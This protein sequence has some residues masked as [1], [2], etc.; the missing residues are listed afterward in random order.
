MGVTSCPLEM[1]FCLLPK[2]LN[3]KFPLF[4]LCRL[5]PKKPELMNGPQ[6]EMGKK[7]ADSHILVLMNYELK[8]ISKR[9]I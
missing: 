2:K 6:E 4:F 8:P 9:M 5:V 3:Q 1:Y 7:T